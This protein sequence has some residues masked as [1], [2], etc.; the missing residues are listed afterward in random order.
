MDSQRVFLLDPPIFSGRVSP[1]S[2]KLTMLKIV[3]KSNPLPMGVNPSRMKTSPPIIA[4][5]IAREQYFFCVS[6]TDSI[7]KCFSVL[8]LA[9]GNIQNS[10]INGNA[11]SKNAEQDKDDDK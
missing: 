1:I 7:I 4:T 3:P 8:L 11:T 2:T 9:L 6:L 10:T 5:V